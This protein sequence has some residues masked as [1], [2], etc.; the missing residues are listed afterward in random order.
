M[1]RT[2]M[3]LKDYIEKGKSLIADY[4]WAMVC[5]DLALM[6]KFAAER[7]QLEMEVLSKGEDFYYEYYMGINA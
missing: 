1:K 6:E 3:G 4:Q 7:Q 2:N 5:M